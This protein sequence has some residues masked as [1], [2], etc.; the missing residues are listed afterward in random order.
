MGRPATATD[1]SPSRIPRQ[2][3]RAEPATASVTGWTE[4]GDGLRESEER[5][6]SLAEHATDAIIIIDLDDRIHFA[7]QAVID[8]FGYARSELDTL[9]F[10]AL[11]PER[12]RGR[13]RAGLLR[14]AETGERRISWKGVELPGLRKDGREIPLE[15]TF[16]TYEQDGRRYF[17][18]IMRDATERKRV[19]ERLRLLAE[20]GEVLAGLPDYRL[21]LELVARSIVGSL[22]DFCLIDVLEDGAL[23]RLVAAHGSP[24]GEAQVS[25][26]RHITPPPS[27]PITEA[28]ESGQPLLV[29]RVTDDVVR[30]MAVDDAHHAAL[31]ATGLRS[32]MVVPLVARGHTIGVVTFAASASGRLYDDDDL[33]LAA[34][35]SRRAALALDNARL[36]EEA[37]RR[38][39]EESAL[40][41]A[42][43]SLAASFTVQ[44]VVDR[45]AESAADATDAD[46]AFVLQLDFAANEVL[47]VSATGR[48]APTKG[49]RRAYEGSLTQRVIER[50][51]PVV[52]ESLADTPE[53][54]AQE[55]SRLCGD[56]TAVVVPLLDSGQPVG[57]LVL[58]RSGGR[59]FH[60]DEIARAVTFVHLAALAFRKVHLLADSER[61]REE[62]ERITESRARLM[63]GF[64]HDLRNPLGAADGHAQLLEAG[65]MGELGPRQRD[66][67]MRIRRALRAALRLI[68]D[69]LHLAR[70]EAGEIEL[71]R[72][73]V[74]VREAAREMAE[75]YRAQAE[76]KKLSVTTEL[77]GELPLTFSDA[78]RVRQI[79]GNLLSN[80][81]KY[82]DRGGI[83]VRVT[84]REGGPG[85]PGAGRWITTEVRDTGRGIGG[86]DLPLL[87][88]EFV[89]LKNPGEQGAG[90]GLAIARRMA[91]A[92]S[93]DITVHSVPGE[94]SVFTL[95]L[96]LVEPPAR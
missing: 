1:L 61:R 32:L 14:F 38:A 73:P 76:A 8:V 90:I 86:D 9:P 13:H 94:G 5:F 24:D 82:T 62:I 39:S 55:L 41:Q 51:E 64:S 58:V 65:L 68:D 63:R 87:F 4:Q 11:M 34:E 7:N 52:I 75:E 45:T 40:F 2:R 96:P 46:G 67:V 27:S 57:S 42:A 49:M 19:E 95:W 17:S 60:Q 89:R 56:C 48:A 72:A 23:R 50:E 10:S 54:I 91:G 18:G 21:T 80:A 29:A 20:T 15:I 92:L 3:R 37:G 71:T 31:V 36:F 84:V 44:D 85:A 33:T 74:D 26:L 78:G 35:L 22:A 47:V 53:P 69:L 28:M 43:R 30:R 83:G 16:G 59:H 66:S 93:G 70:A 6:R 25:R 88:Q 79:L 77:P 12:F 81:I